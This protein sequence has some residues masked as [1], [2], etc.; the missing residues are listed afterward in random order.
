MGN[1]LLKL[2]NSKPFTNKIGELSS[3]FIK[4]NANNPAAQN[5]ALEKSTQEAAKLQNYVTTAVAGY[6]LLQN[7]SGIENLP[8]LIDGL[9]K[10]QDF[11]SMPSRFALHKKNYQFLNNVSNGYHKTEEVDGFINIKPRI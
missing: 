5:Y 7:G 11:F 3:S 10:S 1:F 9:K 2:F 6:N 4:N 8:K